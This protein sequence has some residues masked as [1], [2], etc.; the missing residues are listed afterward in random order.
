MKKCSIVLLFAA[1]CALSACVGPRYK[2]TADGFENVKN[3]YRE[4]ETV[5]IWYPYIATDTDYWFTS[6]D[7]DFRQDYSEEKGYILEFVM[8]AKDVTIVTHSRN[9]MEYNP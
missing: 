7:V 9:S 8:P 4:G 6:E 3:S 1:F 2:V 5:K